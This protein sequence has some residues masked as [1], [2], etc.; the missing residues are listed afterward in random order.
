M[1]RIKRLASVQPTVFIAGRQPSSADISAFWQARIVGM[2]QNSSTETCIDALIKRT[3]VP[4]VSNTAAQAYTGASATTDL[5][6]F[7]DNLCKYMHDEPN[8]GGTADIP[9]MQGGTP[10]FPTNTG[11]GITGDPYLNNCVNSH[12][13]ISYWMAKKILADRCMDSNWLTNVMPTLVHDT[14]EG[15]MHAAF[16]C[17]KTKAMFAEELDTEARQ[18]TAIR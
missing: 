1:R 2:A 15:E 10:T 17:N 8:P 11:L 18:A 5:A 12:T 4:T 16:G 13:G 7:Q 14:H 3:A 9:G 6:T